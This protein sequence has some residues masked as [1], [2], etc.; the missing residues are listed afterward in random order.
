[1][2]NI[3]V[4]LKKFLSNKN[5]VTIVGV[6]AAIVVLYVG[7]NWRVKQA[8]N[9][10][11][12]PYALQEIDPSTQITEDMVGETQVPPA[13]LKSEVVRSKQSVID[14][15]SRADTVIPAG[16]LFYSSVVVEKDQLPDSIILDYPKGY[17]L[18][19]MTVNMT[20][21]YSNSIYP[22]NY[23]DL[24]FK[25]TYA[26]GDENDPNNGKVMVGKLLE[27]VKVLAVR[28]SNGKNVFSNVNEN[29]VP[30]MLIFAVPE[31]HYILLKKAGYLKNYS[32]EL[33]PVPTAESLKTNPGDL[34]LSSN[35]I[36][37]FINSVTVW[38][39][40]VE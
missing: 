28:D 17:V 11:T 21:T 14:K 12:V 19:Y 13:M 32:T 5:T 31:E 7:Y 6:I 2:N 15:Y 9:P 33:S 26:S 35:D 25:A 40:T 1:M 39:D 4:G 18:Y 22:D 23:I 20:T 30:A 36:K 37:N 38:T 29:S 3:T 34:K 24:Y 10:I 16:S 8:T 27:N